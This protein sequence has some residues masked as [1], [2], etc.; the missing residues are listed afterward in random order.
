MSLAETEEKQ[1]Q[2]DREEIQD[3]AE[4]VVPVRLEETRGREW[5]AAIRE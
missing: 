3:K 4:M 5:L 2:A 1:V